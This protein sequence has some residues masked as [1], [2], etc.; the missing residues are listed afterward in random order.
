MTPA[1]RNRCSLVDAFA[2]VCLDGVAVTSNPERFLREGHHG[3]SYR[4]H[5]H[6][7]R[8]QRGW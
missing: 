5:D 2:L 4:G 3:R 8:N 1:T 7:S 6:A